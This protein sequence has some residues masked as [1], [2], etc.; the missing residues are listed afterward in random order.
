VS[1]QHR[2]SLYVPCACSYSRYGAECLEHFAI[3]RARSIGR[4]FR[5]S[6]GPTSLFSAA[7]ALAKLLSNKRLKSK[8]TVHGASPEHMYIWQQLVF[9]YISLTA[10][11]VALC[12][13]I[14]I[15]YAT[16]SQTCQRYTTLPS[17]WTTT[18]AAQRCCL[19]KLAK[20]QQ[21]CLKTLDTLKMRG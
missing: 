16:L 15:C 2:N 8:P 7:V 21:T 3:F 11:S 1:S 14:C 20:M 5:C 6:C 17:I 9:A 13:C 19:S 12:L 4:V 18:Q 10:S